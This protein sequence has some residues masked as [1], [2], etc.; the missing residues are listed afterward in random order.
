MGRLVQGDFGT[1]LKKRGQ[2]VNDIIKTRFPVSAKVG[3]IAVLLAVCIGIPLGSV[4]ALNRGKWIDNL[5][6]FIATLV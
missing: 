5:I 3:A 4:A 1:S 2:E 6:M